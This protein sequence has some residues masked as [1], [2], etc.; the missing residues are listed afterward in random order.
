MK[1]FRERV[2]FAIH[3]TFALLTDCPACS[4]YGE[5]GGSIDKWSDAAAERS[6]IVSALGQTVIEAAPV[7]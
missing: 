2:I 6:P 4:R 5:S 7:F 3:V 1:C